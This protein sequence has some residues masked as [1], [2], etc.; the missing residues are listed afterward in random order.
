MLP[1][2]LALAFL[3]V[4]RIGVP[5][6][7]MALGYLV[8]R[9][10]G[11]HRV[12]VRTWDRYE[13]AR[14][15]STGSV[16]PWLIRGALALLALWA[17][18]ALIVILRFVRGLGA[19]TA[20]SDDFPWGLW[21]GFD[22]LCGV[23][24]AAGGF[25]IAGAVHVF[26]LRR[27]RPVL[28]PAVLTAF[29][30]Y[31]LV[32]AALLLDLGRP[33]RIWHPLIMWQHHSIMFEVAWCVTCYTAVL[34]VE[35]SPMVLEKFNLQRPLRV[36]RAITLPVVI[37]GVILSTLHQSSLGSLYLLVPHKLSPVWYSPLLPVF[38]FTSAIAVGPAMVIVESV[39]SA[40]AFKHRVETD[41]LAG[42]GRATSI[43][44]LIYALL[45]VGDLIVRG[46]LPRLAEVSVIS[47]FFWM[48]F[49]LGV[50]IPLYLLARRNL[51]ESPSRLFRA[52]S[53]VVAGVVLNR[54]NV[55]TVGMMARTG[56]V[57]V[58]S[59][60]EIAVTLSLVTAGVAAFGLA[61][62]FLPVFHGEVPER[63]GHV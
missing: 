21:I 18:T 63:V 16:S 26:N 15:A 51:A 4:L 31:L 10:L 32:I 57:Y 27:Y 35:F 1:D 54:L 44:L 14:P 5:I 62:R 42:L 43:V 60:M 40:R 23:A 28:R 11:V 34:A 6:L 39:L 48:E 58:P 8:L 49:G 25:V 59:W 56:P 2:I 53:L 36:V 3:F 12:V 20:L 47:L 38:F 33:Y 50:L 52:A 29:L 22:V 45:K 24:L 9:T 55:S 30:G 61:A 41:L 37:L 7:I 46:V 19:V 13:P 17:V